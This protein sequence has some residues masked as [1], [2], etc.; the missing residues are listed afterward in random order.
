MGMKFIKISLTDFI[1]FVAKVG[2]TKYSQVKKVKNREDYQPAFDFWKP[3]RDAI[4]ELHKNNLD[5]T[6]LDNVLK[7]LSDSKKLKAYP[8]LVKQYKSFLGRKNL[9][10]FEPPNKTWKSNQLIVQLNP[11]L[12]LEINGKLHVIKLYF[13]AEALSKRKADLILLLLSKQLKKGDYKEVDFCILDIGSKKLFD[14]KT[15]NEEYLPLLEGEA[16]S[17]EV[18][19][20]S[21]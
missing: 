1:D 8:L 11:E 15:L 3:L 2:T 10:W 16:R 21:I 17:F 5:K 13:K 12:G 14:S 20:N 6:H 4:I 9:S 18:I 7:S 19:W